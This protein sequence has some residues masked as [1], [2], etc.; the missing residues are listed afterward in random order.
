VLDEFEHKAVGR[1]AESR[2]E[3]IAER[4]MQLNLRLQLVVAR[5][6]VARHF[7]LNCDFT[8]LVDVERRRLL[9]VGLVGRGVAV[10]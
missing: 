5:R 7:D 4:R 6:I 9:L 2:L 3:A 10:D 1:G 8:Q